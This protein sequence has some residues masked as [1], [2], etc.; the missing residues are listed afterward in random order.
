MNA[1]KW[2]FLILAVSGFA[3]GM[4]GPWW[5]GLAVYLAGAV[6]FL[7][8]YTAYFLET[9]KESE[10]APRARAPCKER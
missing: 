9:L 5:C 8:G 10:I 1:A 3:V 7:G 6:G 2:T 4:F